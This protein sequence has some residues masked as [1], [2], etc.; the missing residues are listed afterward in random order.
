M[1]EFFLS[2][3]LVNALYFYTHSFCKFLHAKRLAIRYPTKGLFGASQL[4]IFKNKNN[5]KV[6]T[7]L[8]VLYCIVKYLVKALLHGNFKKVSE[9]LLLSLLNMSMKLIFDIK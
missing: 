2:L 3:I 7:V 6:Y 4:F 1:T 5:F 9:T 8:Y